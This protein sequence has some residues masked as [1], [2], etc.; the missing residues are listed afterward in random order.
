MVSALL[1]AKA[2]A[3]RVSVELADGRVREAAEE[4][5]VVEVLISDG[6]C[7]VGSPPTPPRINWASMAS[8]RLARR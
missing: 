3:T 8:R 2:A 4:S 1:M 6:S 7:W 5:W